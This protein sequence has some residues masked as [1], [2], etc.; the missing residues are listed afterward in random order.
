MVEIM[1]NMKL[2]SNERLNAVDREQK[3]FFLDYLNQAGF[4]NLEELHPL[5]KQSSP[6]QIDD[7]RLK[8]IMMAGI[9]KN[10]SLEGDFLEAKK[11][12]DLSQE[13]AEDRPE[14]I[15]GDTLSFV[16]YELCLFY[17]KINNLTRSKRYAVLARQH[18]KSKNLEIII[19][20]SI[21]NL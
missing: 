14:I 6:D 10:L 16:Y 12:F 8:V 19:R 4:F 3:E 9:G 13:F 5:Y 17:R 11:I 15:K 1:D 18:A 21:C 20:I 2:N 7:D